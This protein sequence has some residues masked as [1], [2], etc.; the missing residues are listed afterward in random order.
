MKL[1]QTNA[2]GYFEMR[3]ESIGG[4]GANLLGKMLGELGAM[5]LGL[6]AA[7]FSSYGSE[8]RGSPVQAFVRWSTGEIRE[9]SPVTH[10]QILG[11]FHERMGKSVTAG[12]TGETCV[13]V[14]TTRTP[15]EAARALS[16]PDCTVLCVDA[17]KLAMECKSRVN[18]VMLGAIVRACGFVPFD[19]AER[20]VRSTVG[21]KYPALCEQ[22]LAGLCRGYNE[23]ELRAVKTDFPQTPYTRPNPK[24]GYST[25]PLGGANTCIGNS[26]QNDLSASR[27]GYLPLFVPER[28]IHCGLCDSTCPDMVF[29]FTADSDGTMKNRGLDYHHCKGCLRCV[30]VCPTQALVRGLEREHPNPDHWVQNR[31]L[32]SDVPAFRARAADGAVTSESNS[33][34]GVL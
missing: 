10:P 15:E 22:N 7:S 28:C 4:M 19:A 25:A 14:N 27:E 16:L 5:Y 31:D 8:K 12:V 30:E 17:Q 29:R 11:I 21:K 2:G 1:P 33:D 26:I 9:N 20:L 34:G 13:V 24:W 32:I 6:N 18:M 3:L 23:Y